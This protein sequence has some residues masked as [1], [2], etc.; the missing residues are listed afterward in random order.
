MKFL[1]K[2]YI[3]DSQIQDATVKVRVIDHADVANIGLSELRSHMATTSV[4]GREIK[5]EG[6]SYIHPTL[7]KLCARNYC[8]SINFGRFYSYNNPSLK[9][10]KDFLSDPEI[11]FVG[12]G[13]RQGLQKLQSNDEW[14]GLRGV[15]VGDLAGKVLKKS[16]LI[17]K[18]GV[19]IAISRV[20]DEVGVSLDELHTS[21]FLP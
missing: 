18:P 5:S 13:F 20:A 4:V 2:M 6:R 14:K 10:L 8:L 12:I 16:D 7:V 1:S 21:W 9:G 3:Y 19:S 15:E 11:C 17:S